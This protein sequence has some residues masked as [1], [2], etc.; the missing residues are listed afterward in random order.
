M[1]K[2]ITLG[3][4][5][6]WAAEILYLCLIRISEM[7]EIKIS[8]IDKYMHAFFYFVFSVLWFY[9]FRFYFKKQSRSKLLVIVF[10]MSLIFGIAIELFQTYFTTYR[11]GD[12]SDVIANTAGSILAVLCIYFFDKNDFL[13]HIPK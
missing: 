12:I 13:S 5:V 10:V 2:K 1:L 11:N 6:F 9:A 3:A 8:Y 4:A 7:P